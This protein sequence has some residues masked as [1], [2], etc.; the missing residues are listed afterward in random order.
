MERLKKDPNMECPYVYHM[1]RSM[2]W[3]I[4]KSF[5]NWVLYHT[6]INLRSQHSIFFYLKP[7][8]TKENFI[9]AS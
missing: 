5:R 9:L 8:L 7:V 3:P 4:F 2:L 6:Y 1:I